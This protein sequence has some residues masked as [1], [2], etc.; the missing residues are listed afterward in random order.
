MHTRQ[1]EKKTNF[2]AFGNK[3]DAQSCHVVLGLVLI[4]LLD[5][6]GSTNSRTTKSFSYLAN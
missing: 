5:Y 6:T 1:I 3:P 4:G 2:D